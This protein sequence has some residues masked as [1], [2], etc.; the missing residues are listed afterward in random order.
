MFALL[1]C[2]Y[3][4]RWEVCMQNLA[5]T[6][7]MSPLTLARGTGDRQ[8]RALVLDMRGG[9][10]WGRELYDSKTSGYES[11][12]RGEDLFDFDESKVCFGT[13]C[14]DS[15]SMGESDREEGVRERKEER[16]ERKM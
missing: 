1:R 6:C 14:F 12:G 5:A 7:F 4:L 9:T 16:R 11:Y 3:L 2:E 13:V 8:A 10:Y 15:A